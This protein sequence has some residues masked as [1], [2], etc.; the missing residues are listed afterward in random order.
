MRNAVYRGHP[1]GSI[2]YGRERQKMDLGE[3]ASIGQRVILN[4]FSAHIY[5]LFSLD[6]CSVMSYTVLKAEF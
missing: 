5:L 3:K 2:K 4:F 6:K 1:R